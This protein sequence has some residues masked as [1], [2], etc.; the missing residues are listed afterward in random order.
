MRLDAYLNNGDAILTMI[1]EMVLMRN[2]STAKI[3]HVQQINLHAEMAVAFLFIGS[4]M[5]K[6]TF[7]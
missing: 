2:S 1:V 6:I 7:N 3:Q 5:V 4:A